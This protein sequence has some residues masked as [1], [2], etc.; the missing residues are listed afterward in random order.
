MVEEWM[1][2]LVLSHIWG[3]DVMSLWM[4]GYDGQAKFKKIKLVMLRATVTEHFVYVSGIFQ[5]SWRISLILLQEM[6]DYSV[7][8]NYYPTELII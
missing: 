8:A 5:S 7:T 2:L 1:K 4:R 6:Q 3:F